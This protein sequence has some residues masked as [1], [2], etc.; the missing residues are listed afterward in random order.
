MIPHV[1]QLMTTAADPAWPRVVG[2]NPIPFDPTDIDWPVP[3]SWPGIEPSIADAKQAASVPRMQQIASWAQNPNVL[4]SVTLDQLGNAIEGSIHGWMHY[5][6]SA[7][8]PTADPFDVSPAND[9]LGAPWSSHVNKHFWKLHGWIDDKIDGW[10]RAN[11]TTANLSSAWG[12]P[13]VHIH[14]MVAHDRD[15]LRTAARSFRFRSD[16]NIAERLLMQSAR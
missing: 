4:Q 2:W 13:D 16:P 14:A 6:W 12:G 7:A 8:P 1:N 3:P 9:W 15:G 5:R 10:E 11:N